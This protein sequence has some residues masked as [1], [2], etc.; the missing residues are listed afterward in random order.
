VIVDFRGPDSIRLGLPAPDTR[1]VD[2]Y[3]AMTRLRALAVS[4]PEWN[5]MAGRMPA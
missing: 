1:F 2:V 4:S 3:D 5:P